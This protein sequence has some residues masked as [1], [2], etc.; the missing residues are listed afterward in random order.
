MGG[1]EQ[2][3]VSQSREVKR[4]KRWKFAVH[5]QNGSEAS[6]EAQRCVANHVH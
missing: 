6:N 3:R 5:L 1:D 4:Q 2:R